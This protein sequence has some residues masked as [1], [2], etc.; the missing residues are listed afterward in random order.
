V[1]IVSCE[2]EKQLKKKRKENGDEPI[3]YIFFQPQNSLKRM[4]F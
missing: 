3:T 2:N 1:K 4:L